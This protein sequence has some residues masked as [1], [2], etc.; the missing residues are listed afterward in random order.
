MPGD[1]IIEGYHLAHSAGLP[2]FCIDLPLR[3]PIARENR[4]CLPD[5][6]F[7]PR[8]GHVFR[9]AVDAL[10][11]ATPPPG[12][13]ARE[14]HMAA[15][16]HEL[17][18]EYPKVLWVGGMAHWSRM[19]QRLVAEDFITPD[20]PLAERPTGFRRMR[21]AP[22]A[23]DSMTGRM[24][25]QV[26]QFARQPGRYRDAACLQK[27]ALAAVKPET[28]RAT[29]VAAMLR[30]ARNIAAQEDLRET[31]R[32]WDL[33]TSASSMLGNEYAARLASL[34]LQP[35]FSAAS[36]ALPELEY[37]TRETESG[38]AIGEY[39]SEGQVL[40]GEPLLS[41]PETFRYLPL[42]SPGEI[43]R[44]ARNNPGHDIKQPKAEDSRRWVAPPD[45]E[46][47]YEAFVRYVLKQGIHND[48]TEMAAV[49]LSS[50]MGDGIDVRATIRHWQS[51]QIYVREPEQRKVL[52]TNGLIDFRGHSENERVVNDPFEGWIDPDCLN[53]GSVSLQHGDSVIL[54]EDPFHLR[55]VD[56]GLSLI[57]LDTPTWIEGST[58]PSFYDR[59]IR[60]L[61]ELGPFDHNLYDW[62]RIMFDFCRHKPFAYCSR[63]KPSK[64]IHAIGQEFG[65]RVIHVPLR[66]IAKTL[67]ERHQS[68]RYMHMTKGQWDEYLGELRE[69]RRAWIPPETRQG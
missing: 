38:G 5:A 59:V 51:G 19:C 55:R 7:A 64:E 17:M 65:V 61:V 63:Y 34:A 16:L 1:S 35:H 56:R 22:S 11:T 47:S 49:P 36:L 25:F 15:R 41:P 4:A 2:V 20:L 28:F 6:A 67:R 43:S 30:Y 9:Q 50:G 23:L 13:V 29:E 8:V 18:A 62:L 3:D 45:E 52:V 69:S 40:A 21:L 60:P 66:R 54:Q 24:P 27:L 33:L 42:P 10:D 44:R 12:D 32:L 31:P 26:A 53:V 39:K 14:A 68:F 57:T 46:S 58:R 37:E 48:R